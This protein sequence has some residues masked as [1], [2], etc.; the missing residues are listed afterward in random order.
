[1]EK[2]DVM[3]FSLRLTVNLFVFTDSFYT[4][5]KGN[6]PTLGAQEFIFSFHVIKIIHKMFFLPLCC[7]NSVTDEICSL[8]PL[9]S[10]RMVLFLETV[11]RA[12]RHMWNKQILLHDDMNLYVK[13]F[14]TY[15]NSW[16]CF[17][18]NSCCFLE[19]SSL[20]FFRLFLS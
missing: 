15:L 2:M 14:W 10:T 3:C 18:N 19:T 12:K 9:W 5:T 11:Q 16:T 6:H 1:M 4:N 17:F 8:Q 7:Q 13:N 20:I